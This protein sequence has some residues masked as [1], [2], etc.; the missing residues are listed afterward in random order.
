M[1]VKTKTTWGCGCS[2]KDAEPAPCDTAKRLRVACA[3]YERILYVSDDDCRQ[4][5]TSRGPTAK[6]SYDESRYAKEARRGA[7]NEEFRQA[8]GGAY[9]RET[10]ERGRS[11]RPKP[12]KP[13][14]YNE[15][16]SKPTTQKTGANADDDG[17][18]EIEYE[19]SWDSPRGARKSKVADEDVDFVI[20][21]TPPE[22]SSRER[23]HGTRRASMPTEDYGGRRPSGKSEY[24][25]SRDEFYRNKQRSR[26][27]N[28]QPRCRNS[29]D[30]ELDFDLDE[31]LSPRP[32]RSHNR[33]SRRMG[34][35]SYPSSS[36]RTGLHDYETD[37]ELD[38]D[39]DFDHDIRPSY[40][41]SQFPRSFTQGDRFMD[42]F[43]SSSGLDGGSRRY[44]R[45]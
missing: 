15:K 30:S 35:Y 43:F 14:A 32:R 9:D 23:R 3:K 5:R 36:R 17:P 29:L 1:C 21:L 45:Y 4:C 20:D 25:R 13:A 37:Y 6:G 10:Y 27:E 22:S 7:R 12:Y 19:Y 39:D 28:P 33:G 31:E 2:V 34:D 38:Y 44:R 40:T 11:T 18:E 41:S 24:E 8:Y 26:Y 16:Q 42:S